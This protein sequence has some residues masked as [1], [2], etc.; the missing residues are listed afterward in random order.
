VVEWGLRW[1]VGFLGSVA[2][3]VG[4]VGS[5][6]ATPLGGLLVVSLAVVTAAVAAAPSDVGRADAVHILAAVATGLL[7]TA[8]PF[9]L[10][11][12]AIRDIEVLEGAPSPN[13]VPVIGTGLA[14]LLLGDVLGPVQELTR[15]QPSTGRAIE[16]R[17]LLRWTAPM[18]A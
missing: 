3:G 16:E 14:V 13:F 1:G 12:T 17:M 2:I 18:S 11:N 8:V 5:G 4:A 10:F 9:L 6:H 15:I 7:T